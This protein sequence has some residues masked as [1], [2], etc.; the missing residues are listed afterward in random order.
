MMTI[1]VKAK[2]KFF[3]VLLLVLQYFAKLDFAQVP[4]CVFLEIKRLISTIPGKNQ[5]RINLIGFN[6]RVA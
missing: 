3:P 1:Q 6:T 5:L 4:T 2:M